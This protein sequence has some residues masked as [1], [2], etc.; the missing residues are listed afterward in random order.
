MVPAQS[1]PAPLFER[2]LDELPAITLPEGFTVQG[3]GNLD[4]G[5]CGPAPPTAHS[6]PHEDWGEGHWA[7]YAQFMGSAVYEGE[8]DLFVRSPDGCGASASQQHDL[9]R[10]S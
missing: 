5:H 2:T 7:V 4:D 3:V 1:S 10:P 8:R 6:R 9:V